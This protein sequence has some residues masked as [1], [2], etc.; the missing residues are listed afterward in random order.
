[1]AKVDVSRER[2]L[3]TRFA[4]RSVPSFFVIDGWSVYLY[5]GYYTE[6]KLREFVRGGYKLQDVRKN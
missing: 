5:D 3:K 1:M 4:V 2:A 6:A